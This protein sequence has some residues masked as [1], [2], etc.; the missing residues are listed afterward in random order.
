MDH[1]RAYRNALAKAEAL[2]A[3]L[4][5]V[6]AFLEL[7]REF[8]GR[9]GD[10]PAEAAPPARSPLQLSAAPNDGE[11]AGAD[12][13][14]SISQAEMEKLAREAILDAGRPL[15]RKLLLRRLAIL[16]VRIGGADP[17]KNVGTK[18]WRARDKFVNLDRF[19]YWPSDVPNPD[20]GYDPTV[21]TPPAGAGETTIITSNQIDSD[22]S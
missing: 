17:L 9:E 21:N 4:R 13:N 8:A 19:G 12:D 14:M 6:E 3:E 18:M 22:E 11:H 1:D 10:A 7:Y 16:G 20:H 5:R 2:R 15:T